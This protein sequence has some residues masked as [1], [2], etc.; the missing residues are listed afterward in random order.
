MFS[1]PLPR[2]RFFTQLF[3]A[4]TGSL[5]GLATA[6]IPAQAPSPTK[7][8]W[9]IMEIGWEYNDEYTYAE[10]N[11]LRSKMYLDKASADA[12]CERLCAEFFAAETPIGFQVEFEGYHLA[13]RD[14]ETITWEELRAEGFPDPYFVELIQTTRNQP[15]HE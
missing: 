7:E 6:V 11:F 8:A 13:D 14:P 4:G 2:R 10:G 1:E 12:E 9:V 3:T 15:Y 5:A